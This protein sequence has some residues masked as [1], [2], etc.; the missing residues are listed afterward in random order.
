MNGTMFS[1]GT[2]FVGIK[3]LGVGDN[4]L[5]QWWLSLCGFDGATVRDEVPWCSAAVN[6]WAWDLRMPR[7][8]SAMARSWLGVGV[9]ILLSEARPENDI[10]I[11]RRSKAPTAT[12]GHVG[13]YAGRESGNVLTLGGNQSNAVSVLPYS[14]EDLIGVRRLIT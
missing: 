9:P 14:I 13:V 11:F 1:R 4:P 3:E 10:V 8:K 2:R 7:S 6:G 5:I 12:D